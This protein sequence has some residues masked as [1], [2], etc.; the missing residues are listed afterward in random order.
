M[1]KTLM[2][3]KMSKLALALGLIAAAGAT[4]AAALTDTANLTVNATV[5]NA[6]AIGPGTLGFGNISMAVTA[7]AG[8]AAATAAVDADSGT[9]VA[10]V[11][12]TGSSATVTGDNGSNYSSG[13]RMRI[14]ATADY[15]GYELYTSA[16]RTTVLDTSAGSIAYTGTGADGY[17][18]I[19]GRITAANLA[20][21]KAGTY[22][23]VVAL[24]VTYTP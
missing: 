15:L 11:C 24:T 9:S 1:G 13:R 22:T 10:I 18:T 17:V 21:A 4:M 23:D 6:C 20:A 16:G 2:R 7:G 14:L 19:Y 12:T 8:T 5:Q 3:T